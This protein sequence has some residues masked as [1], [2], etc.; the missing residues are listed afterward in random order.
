MPAAFLRKQR[1]ICRS[2]RSV[3][4][5]RVIMLEE[6]IFNDYKQAMKDKDSL[7]S[8]VLS[9]LRAQI[10]NAATAKKKNNLDDKECLDGIRKQIAMRQDSIAQFKSGNRLD[11]AEKE[12][13]ELEILKAYL[14]PQLSEDEIKKIVEE[15]GRASGASSLKDMGRVMKAVTEKK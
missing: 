7:K 3:Q 11:L 8:S 1:I 15:I 6:K 13:R 9:F 5:R 2:A 10:L 12:T 4:I 14:P